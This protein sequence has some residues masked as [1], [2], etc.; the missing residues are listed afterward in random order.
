MLPETFR[1]SHDVSLIILPMDDHYHI[2]NNYNFI[3]SMNR[4]SGGTIHW[5]YIIREAQRIYRLVDLLNTKQISKEEF[6]NETK[7][8]CVPSPRTDGGESKNTQ[9]NTTP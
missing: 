2:T 3:I 9:I 5:D 4:F 6:I 7:G 8:R 1:I